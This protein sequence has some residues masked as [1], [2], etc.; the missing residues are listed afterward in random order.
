MR[1]NKRAIAKRLAFYGE[2]VKNNRITCQG[3]GYFLLEENK[4]ISFITKLIKAAIKVIATKI[5]MIVSYVD[6]AHHLL[7]EII[8]NR[9]GSI[10]AALL[11]IAHKIII[12]QIPLDN[13]RDFFMSAT[14][15]LL[16]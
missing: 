5:I 11:L 1:S 4:S 15:L 10:H 6:I 7:S 16:N 3:G 12:Q 13:K 9:C 8:A 14:N 2:L